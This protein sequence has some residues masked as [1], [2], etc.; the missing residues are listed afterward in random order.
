MK[1]KDVFRKFPKLKQFKYVTSYKDAYRYKHEKY[2][3]DNKVLL[4]K[5]KNEV[6]EYYIMNRKETKLVRFKNVPSYFRSDVRSFIDEKQIYVIGR[7][8]DYN[9]IKV[10]SKFGKNHYY[11]DYGFYAIFNAIS[12]TN[13]YKHTIDKP[14]KEYSLGKLEQEKWYD[15]NKLHREN[16]PALIQYNIEGKISDVIYCLNGKKCNEFQIE[17]IK[18]LEKN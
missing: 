14:C 11:V 15:T 3:K 2:K 5:E 1:I 8:K 6:V 18:Q 12:F 10:I 7:Y 16:G 17:V 9:Y 13:F 4:I